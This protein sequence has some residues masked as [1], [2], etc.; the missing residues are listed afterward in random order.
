MALTKVTGQVVNTSTDLTVGVLTATTAS[1]TGNVSV[2][3]TLTYEDVTNVDS[4]GLITARNGVNISGGNLQVGGTN[5]INSGRAL[6]NIEEIKLSDTKELILGSGDDLKIY[7]SGSHS[8]ISEEGAGALKIKGDDI[9]FEN[10]SATEALRITSNGN[11]GI[12]TASPTAPLAV[13]SSSDPEIRFGYNETQDHKISW[14]SSKVFL[15]A[16]PDNAN[17]SSALGFKVD[18]TEAA[19]FDSSGRLLLGTTTEGH[20][21]LDDLTIAT[22]AHTGITIRSGTTHTGQVGFSDGT[23]G[24]DEYRGQVVYSHN[25]DSMYFTTNAAERMRIDSSGRLMLG[26][27]IEGYSSGDDLTI[28]TSG[29]TGITLRS[30]TTSE[31]AIYFSDNTS[32]AGEYVGSLVYSHNTNSM[33]FTANGAERMRIDSSGNMGLGTA[34]PSSDGGTTLEIYNATTPTLRLNDGGEYKA[35]FQLRGNDLEV[36]GSNGAME[37]YTGNA[38]G[39]SSTERMRIDSSGNIIIGTTAAAD[40]AKLTVRDAAPKLS[41]YATPGNASRL[42]MGDTDDAD[43]GQIAYDN[44]DNSLNFVTNAATRMTI[45]SSGRLMLG[46]T[47]EGEHTADDLTIATSGDTGISIRSGTSSSGRLFFSDGTSSADEYRGFVSYAHSVNALQFG[48]DATE[49]ARIT[50]GGSLLVGQTN[51]SFGNTGHILNASGQHYIIASGDTPLL[52]NR[53]SNDGE[54]IRLAKD[55][56]T[57]GNITNSGADVSYNPFM[58]SHWGRLED[59]SKPE[60]LPGTILESVNKL[61]EWK[62]VEFEVDGVQKREAYNGSEENGA[63]V[64]VEYEGVSY[65]GTVADEEPDSE[66]LNKHVCV[67][68]SDTAAS[69]AVFGVFFGWDESETEGIIGSWN[70]ILCAALGNYYIRIKSGQSLEIGDLIESD[71]S[72]CG[73][74]QSD[75]IIRTKTVAKVTSTTP[76]KVYTDGSFLVTCVLYCG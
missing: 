58:G 67:K 17:G 59:N 10:A 69:K 29:H 62:V 22:A 40:S 32:G 35:L 19:R 7:H 11:I 4:V 38:D 70:D 73:V 28:A 18:G 72:G 5:V 61:V 3:G 45:D 63:S 48:T 47:T 41:L 54:L 34:S 13:M 6:L 44:S 36:R 31:G 12:G 21:N 20:P 9:R 1:F 55:G 26:T 37:F 52:I 46:T 33:N 66:N 65:T 14:D 71:G 56:S 27:T 2:G 25:T 75:D 68:V 50:S 74:V 8:F 23:S 49:R 53:Q 64:T 60:I 39:A 51:E 57:V 24:D 16:D 30:G 43:I 42:L 15:E 76:Q